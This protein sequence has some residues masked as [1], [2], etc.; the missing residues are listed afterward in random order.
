MRVK[1]ALGIGWQ[2]KKIH[3]YP[4]ALFYLVSYVL[5]VALF[6]QLIAQDREMTEP[7]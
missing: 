6:L 7:L 4:N 2:N 3:I 5:F 1:Y